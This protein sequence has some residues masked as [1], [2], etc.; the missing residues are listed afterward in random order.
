MLFVGCCLLVADYCVLYV[1][2]GLLIV[3][4][5]L[6]FVDAVVVVRRSLF[7]DVGC[8]GCCLLL[9]FVVCGLLLQLSLVVVCC[10]S[11]VVCC[12]L[13]VV[14]WLLFVVIWCS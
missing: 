10:S 2:C 14:C 5:F 11:F 1:V 7:V 4:W 9:L 6:S 13:F 8:S 3:V 12:V